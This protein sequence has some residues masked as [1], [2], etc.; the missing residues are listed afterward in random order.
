M[1]RSG[2]YLTPPSLAARL[3]LLLL[4]WLAR[5][6]ESVFAMCAGCAS[7]SPLTAEEAQL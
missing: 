4:R 7:D 2:A 1:H 5:D 3:Y 6:F